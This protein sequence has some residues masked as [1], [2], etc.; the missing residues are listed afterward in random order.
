MIKKTYIEGSIWLLVSIFLG[1]QS[2]KLDLGSFS[3]PGPGFMPFLMAFSLFSLSLIL[4]KPSDL[5]QDI[6]T[7][8]KFD[9]KIGAIYI[10]TSIVGYVFIFKKAGFLFSTFLL[11]IFLFK[12]TG[13][14]TWK[15]ALGGALIVTL[16]SYLFFGEILKL[17]L[18]S[19]IF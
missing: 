16:L 9:L 17:N 13:T 11:M 4:F 2:V 14:K 8:Q 1:I 7:P 18:P 12:F 6:K 10:T 15:W 19:G 3:S 5:F